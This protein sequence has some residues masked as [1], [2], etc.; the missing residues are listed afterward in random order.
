MKILN[1]KKFEKSIW[2]N[3]SYVEITEGE[4][5][6]LFNDY[7]FGTDFTKRELDTIENIANISYRNSFESSYI[8]LMYP[9]ISFTVGKFD[10]EWFTAMI[11]ISTKDAFRYEYYKC[12][13]FDGL[14]N[15][16]KD[17][18]LTKNEKN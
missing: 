8:L 12:D 13:Q 2:D 15:L 17:K 11:I 3:N 1:Y 6:E 16:L 9:G 7:E 5:D 10:D 4:Y 14:I 18:K